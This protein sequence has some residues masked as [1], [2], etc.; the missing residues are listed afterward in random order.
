[1]GLLL[2]PLQLASAFSLSSFWFHVK[3]GWCLANRIESWSL[4]NHWLRETNLHASCIYRSN[5]Q[6][7]R[8]IPHLDLYCRLS[9]TFSNFL[10]W[11]S[12]HV[13]SGYFELQAEISANCLAWYD[14]ARLLRVLSRFHWHLTDLAQLF[15]WWNPS[16][17][18]FILSLADLV[19]RWQRLIRPLS[20]ATTKSK[21]TPWLFLIHSNVHF[22]ESSFCCLPCNV[23][24]SQ[25]L[26]LT[27]TC[28]AYYSHIFAF[29]GCTS[30]LDL[31]FSLIIEAYSVIQLCSTLGCTQVSE[32][33]LPL[34]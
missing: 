6:V 4:V 18:E 25:T 16:S 22:Q 14:L 12:A 7:G 13:L 20:Q 5:L 33:R 29:P 31:L 24:W 2:F 9:A 28:A 15:L 34:F 23:A 32:I 21:S 3:V 11:C 1:M 30:S 8:L 17:R 10:C 19:F 27:F 26:C